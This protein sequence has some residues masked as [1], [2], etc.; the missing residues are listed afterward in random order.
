MAG[1]GVKVYTDE[2]VGIIASPRLRIGALVR[3]TR[4][5]PVTIPPKFQSDTLLWL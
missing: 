5:H 1:L 2:D 4:R 3:R